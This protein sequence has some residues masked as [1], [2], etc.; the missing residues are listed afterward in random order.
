MWGSLD[1][2]ADIFPGGQLNGY[3][4]TSA[5]LPSIYTF[6]VRGHRD[7]PTLEGEPDSVI[8]ADVFENSFKGRT[9]A[10]KDS[11]TPFNGLNFLD[12]IKS[13]IN[14]SRSLGWITNQITA[15]KYT[16]L[17]DSARSSLQANNRG[18]TEA[19]LDEV[20]VNVR[21]DS[22]STLTSEAYALLRFNTEYVLQKLREVDSAFA[23]E[24]KSSS[25]N[26]TATNNAR[27]LAKWGEYLHEVFTS[28]GEIFY[29]RSADGGSTWDQTHWLNTAIGEN[30]RPCITTT[31]G[32]SLHIVWQRKIA[33]SV[34]EVW[35]S[36]SRDDGETWSTPTI[37]PN[38]GE[39]EVSEY[40]TD[41]TMPVIAEQKDKNLVAVYCSSE[42]LRYRISDNDGDSW[43]IPND[44][45]IRGQ[46]DDRVRFPSLAGMDEQMYLLYDYVDDDLSPY[47]RIFD[48]SKWSDENSVAE[49]T[50]TSGG[51]FSSVAIDADK[52]PIA[53]WSTDRVWSRSIVFRAG[54]ADNKWSDWFVEFWGGQ[55]SPDW[56]SPS[57]TY[58]NGEGND[59]R[60]AIV[61]STTQHSVKL[62]RYSTES[63]LWDIGTLSGSGAWASITQGDYFSGIPIYCWTDQNTFPYEIVV[64]SS[65][66]SPIKGKEV[67]TM[68]LLGV[69]QKRRAVVYHRN[70]RATFSLEFEP[71]KIVTTNGDTTLAAFKPASLRERGINFSNMW[72]YLGSDTVRLPSNAQRLIIG[73][74]FTGRGP[75]IDQRKFF[76]RLLNTDGTPIGVLDTTSTSGTVSVNIAPHAGKRVIFRPQVVLTGIA[77]PSVAIGVGDVF[78]V[79][80]LQSKPARGKR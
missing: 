54:Y 32:G 35:H 6:Y 19:R 33:P 14:Q 43:Q 76:L 34:Y 72:D 8:G 75:S 40:Q 21:L 47:S 18:V 22:A 62:I 71:M 3:N 68:S 37:L 15:N 73:K 50:G 11:P 45:I 69:T 51:A 55:L 46:Y 44:D 65:E 29:R 42:G 59:Y 31:K 58:Y 48:G 26:A 64:G 67:T 53:A 80:K 36:Y 28:G 13:Y 60:I 4:I 70:L 78:I 27:D 10:P 74:Q 16:S 20:L 7:V 57:T 9:T 17:I 38:A 25:W 5:G 1:S 24:N 63:Q 52:N 79:P 41:G 30:A 61:H 77:P 23:A 2:L 12:T 66:F 49:G 56:V 39:V